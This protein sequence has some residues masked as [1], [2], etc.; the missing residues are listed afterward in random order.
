MENAAPQNFK[1]CFDWEILENEIDI[2]AHFVEEEKK[3]AEEKLQKD[4]LR[5]RWLRNN[6]NLMP[7]VFGFGKVALAMGKQTEIDK[8]R[9]DSHLDASWVAQ[10]T[11]TQD[12]ALTKVQQPATPEFTPVAAQKL[13]SLL[14]DGFSI[15]GFSI[16]KQ[17]GVCSPAIQGLCTAN[18]LAGWFSKTTSG[19]IGPLPE[20]NPSSSEAQ[21]LPPLAAEIIEI[22]NPTVW[23]ESDFLGDKHVVVQHEGG[24]PFTYATFHYDHEQTS[25]SVILNQAEKLAVELGAKEPV[26][27]RHRALKL[28]NEDAPIPASCFKSPDFLPGA[29]RKLAIFLAKGFNITGYSIERKA[30]NASAPTERGFCTADG[31][32]GWWNPPSGTAEPV[33]DKDEPF[34]TKI[35]S[36]SIQ[37]LCT[38]SGLVCNCCQKC[39]NQDGSDR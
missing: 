22:F 6:C 16:E 27:V 24:D 21:T 30:A 5:Y 10:L 20:N 17:M 29:F 35:S 25:S 32:V 28:S 3:K 31:L 14:A 4:A 12:A 1:P 23:I 34:S 18:G 33:A 38:V 36:R 2:D 39:E 37:G 13:E 11:E 8:Q 26:E 9:L 19:P 15:T 7:S